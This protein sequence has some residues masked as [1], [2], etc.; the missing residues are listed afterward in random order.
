MKSLRIHKN[1]HG[2]CYLHTWRT[3]RI[4][5]Q[6]N[7]DL[8][9]RDWTNLN[10]RF[11]SHHI[12]LDKV[13]VHDTR[14]GI[15]A[16]D[17]SFDAIYSCHV[18]EHFSK[19]LAMAYL[20]E[21]ARVLKPG[22][23]CRISTPNLEREAREYIKQLD[24]CRAD[25][26]NANEARY[27]LARESLLDQMVRTQRGGNL[28]KVIRDPKT[29][30]AY[31]LERYGDV[32]REFVTQPPELK[33]LHYG[34]KDTLLDF[35]LRFAWDKLKLRLCALLGH[36]N[37]IFTGENELWEWDPYGLGKALSKHGF[38]QIKNHSCDSSDVPHWDEYKIDTSFD[39][40]TPIEPSLY[41]E[42]IRK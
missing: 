38:T 37:T 1:K 24:T 3:G 28:I 12:G 7:R 10:H 17:S 36:K 19:D 4:Y 8:L 15:P 32:Y 35:N 16:P 21:L 40:K 13:L 30:P 20:K 41:I 33:P 39:G 18:I 25:P 5:Y 11:H 23:V 9:L 42:A 14:R 2:L 31:A 27:E 26:N 29:D 34:L 22:G 6:K